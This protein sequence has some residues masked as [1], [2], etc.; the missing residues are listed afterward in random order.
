MWPNQYMDNAK[1]SFSP[2]SLWISLATKRSS[3]IWSL[4]IS[5]ELIL[6]LQMWNRDHHLNLISLSISHSSSYTW[7]DVSM[8]QKQFKSQFTIHI[9][10]VSIVLPLTNSNFVL[11]GYWEFWC[12]SNVAGTGTAWLS[13]GSHPKVRSSTGREEC[14]IGAT[15]SEA[16]DEW[17]AQ[18]KA[19]LHCRQTTVRSGTPPLQIFSFL[20]NT[21]TPLFIKEAL[22]LNVNG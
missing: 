14:R 21:L 7:R 5:Y 8:F 3:S 6:T 9:F 1:K 16:Q 22:S 19:I 12:I 2:V 11:L 10:S 13:W 17:G 15:Q 4:V 18:H 20:L